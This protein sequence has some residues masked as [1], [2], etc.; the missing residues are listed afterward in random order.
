M[1]VL[2]TG[3][4]LVITALIASLM[5]PCNGHSRR[6][7]EDCPREWFTT[8]FTA[9]AD[10]VVPV[11]VLSTVIDTDFTYFRDI[12]LFSEEEIEMVTQDAIEFFNT[13]FGLNFSQSTPNAQGQR[14]LG[15]ALLVNFFLPPEFQYT[16]NFNTRILTGS[17]TNY[18]FENREGGFLVIF[19]G[20]ETLHGTYGGTD[21]IPVV[22]GDELIY[23]F[24][25]FAIF[26]RHPLIIQYMTITPV[27]F[28]PVD[29]FGVINFEL[30]H[31]ILGTGTAQGI[32][33]VTAVEPGMAHMIF[34]I[35]FTFPAHPGLN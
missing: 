18:C 6:W 2:K 1:S 22:Q 9:I 25:N 32:I 16:L 35:V 29:G 20:D 24:Y 4:L 3:G 33:R 8:Q 7:S 14:T 34:Y 27:R 23:G 11:E 31:P 13:R 30:Q 10:A 28:A 19:R 26:P 15:N 5:P 21:G 17:T 12:M